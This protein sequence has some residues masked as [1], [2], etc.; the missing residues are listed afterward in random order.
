MISVASVLFVSLFTL[1]QNVTPIVNFQ[2]SLCDGSAKNQVTGTWIMDRGNFYILTSAYGIQNQFGAKSCNSWILSNGEVSSL[3]LIRIDYGAGLALLKASSG[4]EPATALKLSGELPQNFPDQALLAGMN[5]RLLAKSSRRHFIPSISTV[6]EVITPKPV[7]ESVVGEP[8]ISNAGEMLGMVSHQRLEIFPG[9]LTRPMNWKLAGS[10]VSDHL[11]VI[12]AQDILAWLAL[13]P[14]ESKIWPVHSDGSVFESGRLRIEQDCP[15]LDGSDPN[16]DYPIGG[17]DAVG[18]GGDAA[19]QRACKIKV[20]LNDRMNTEFY[21]PKWQEWHDQMVLWLANQPVMEL[22][23]GG[24]RDAKSRLQR[25]YFYSSESFFQGLNVLAESSVLVGLPGMDIESLRQIRELA[26]ELKALAHR[27]YIDYQLNDR[28]VEDVFRRIYFYSLLLESDQ[29]NLLD[30]HDLE[31]LLSSENQYGPA[32][33]KIKF[34]VRGGVG[35]YQ[36][37]EQTKDM[38]KQVKPQ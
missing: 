2:S 34:I 24:W 29:W 30:V 36:G 17:T 3:E 27:S 28:V 11:V 18:I 22:Q 16:G 33:E 20:S 6:L 12:S 10:P 7:R 37:L 23:F 21:S 9:S 35:M 32:W 26:S 19:K 15:P 38:L 25:R 4:V 31:E 14:S 8:L 5:A 13:A 1:A